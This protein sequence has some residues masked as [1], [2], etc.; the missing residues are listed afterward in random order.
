MEPFNQTLTKFTFL[1]TQPGTLRRCTKKKIENFESVQGVIF[2]FI[3]SLLN[4]GKSTE[5]C[6]TIHVKTCAIQKLLLLMLLQENILSW[7]QNRLK[8]TCLIELIWGEKLSSKTQ[9]LFSSSLPQ[10]VAIQ[11]AWGA[12]AQLGLCLELFD[13]YRDATSFPYGHLLI[14]LSP[15]TDT[16]DRLR[17]CTN[18]GSIPSKFFIPERRKH[19]KYL[20]DEYTKFL[21]SPSSPIVFQ[22]MQKAFPSV[23]PKIFYQVS[24]CMINKS[25]QKKPA[26]HKKTSRDKNSERNSSAFFKKNNLETKKGPGIREK[27]TAHKSS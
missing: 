24:D 21:Y 15:G 4:T 22:L 9:R 13:C 7:E 8:V 27:F 19:I 12:T 17:Y 20:D 1:K 23:L 26:R 11:C 14:P 6:P 10:C 18:T 16:D 5:D 25:A 2:D 3:D